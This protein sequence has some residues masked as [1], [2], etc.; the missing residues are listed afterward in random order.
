M[1]KLLWTKL[2]F[3]LLCRKALTIGLVFLVA[4]EDNVNLG[5]VEGFYF[6]DSFD[7]GGSGFIVLSKKPSQS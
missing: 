4:L 3:S 6:V 1:R 2:A 7:A 5:L